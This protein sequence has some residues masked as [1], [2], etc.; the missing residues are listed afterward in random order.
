[1]KLATRVAALLACIAGP[2][3]AAEQDCKEVEVPV[4]VRA[5]VPALPGIF[6]LPSIS[7]YVHL[8]VGFV[9]NLPAQ[10]KYTIRATH[11]TSTVRD[12]ENNGRLQVLVHGICGSR[13]FF[14]GLE[15]PSLGIEAFGGKNYSYVDYAL[16]KGY[17]TL[18]VDRL[19]NGRSDKPN[20][21]LVV[22][23]PAQIEAMDS[24]LEQIRAERDAKRSRAGALT[25]VPIGHRTWHNRLFLRSRPHTSS[26]LMSDSPENTTDGDSRMAFFDLE[27]LSVHGL[28]SITSQ[29]NAV[30]TGHA[31]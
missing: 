29:G 6:D 19:G 7:N 16:S 10:G 4:T 22:H 26:D 28:P 30:V 2:V 18:S 31:A 15:S 20:P 13:H 21:F 1:M 23:L 12:P 8:W 25:I 9:F 5:T 17:D 24:L 3:F 11:C 14:S 27:H